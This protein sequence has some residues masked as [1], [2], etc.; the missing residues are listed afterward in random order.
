[1][2]IGEINKHLISSASS[3]K[4]ALRLLNSL[5]TDL[6]LFVVSDDRRVLGTVTDG[7]IRR[8]LLKDIDI[9]DN[10]QKCMYKDFRFIL[11]EDYSIEVFKKYK[12]LDI[13]IIPILDDDKKIIDIVNLKKR[14]SAIPIE[15]VLMA[16]GKGVRLRPITDTIPKPLIKIG[17]IPILERNI[18]RLA[19]YGVSKIHISINYMGSKIKE[20]IGNGNKKEISIN[21]IE[22]KEPMGT[23]GSV[24]LFKDYKKDIILVMN[25]DI[26][27]NIDFEEMY[28]KMI[29][30]KADFVVASIPYK[31]DVPYAVLNTKEGK[32]ESFK[33]KP[34]Y[35][36]Y[37]NAGIYLIK[38]ELLKHI[39]D[40]SYFN[41]TD[42]MEKL[43]AM[44]KKVIQYPILGYW[45]DIGE[46]E[47]MMRAEKDVSR[48]KF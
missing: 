11:E 18:D 43:I 42:L 4:E 3:I 20:Y 5:G 23:I 41:T 14:R 45:L 13:N 35:V 12:Q 38:K 7:D 24:K 21:Y 6:T 15:A 39:P 2:K 28:I 27:T 33:E 32:V 1:M 9:N 37:S 47:D 26:L 16:G 25:S 44:D 46:P 17:G 29:N 40:N 22:E 31:V 10:V 30:E 48:I 19:S 36:Y 8:A 34:T